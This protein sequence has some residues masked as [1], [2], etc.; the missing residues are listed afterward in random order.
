MLGVSKYSSAG[1]LHLDHGDYTV[2]H[3]IDRCASNH[4]SNATIILLIAMYMH[5]LSIHC[6]PHDIKHSCFVGMH[7]ISWE[8]DAYAV[9]HDARCH[10]ECVH[11]TYWFNL[12]LNTCFNLS[13]CEFAGTF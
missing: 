5:I 9:V 6:F 8:Q 10:F 1:L 13:L 11:A 12:N 2:V 4:A 7:T 3:S